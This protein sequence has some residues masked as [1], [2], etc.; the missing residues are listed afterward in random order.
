M[1]MTSSSSTPRSAT[2]EP[3]SP[4]RYVPLP[5]VMVRA[6][7]FPM[8]AYLS[9]AEGAP[10]APSGGTPR[11]EQLPGRGALSPDNRWVRLALAAGAPGLIEALGRSSDAAAHEKLLAF[12]IRMSTRPTPYGLFAGVALGAWGDRTNLSIADAAP[13]VGVRLDMEW[14]YRLIEQL[15]AR[16]QIRESL[17]VVA[18]P[19]ALVAGGRVFLTETVARV[20]DRRASRVSIRATRVVRAILRAARTPVSYTELAESMRASSGAPLE[21]VSRLLDDL[22]ERTFLLTDLRPPHSENPARHV[23]RRLSAIP[24]ARAEAAVLGALV[25][26]AAAWDPASD[27]PTDATLRDLAGR[28]RAI[29]QADHALQVDAALP[30]AGRTIARA[31]GDEFAR[32]AEILIRLTPFPQGITDFDAYRRRF[33]ARYGIGREVPVLEL[34]DPDFGLGPPEPTQPTVLAAR[35]A[36]LLRIATRALHERQTVVDLDEAILAELATW[37]PTK[38]GCPPSLDL[39]AF[40]SAPSAAALEADQFQ[41]IVGPAVGVSGAGRILGRFAGLL[42]QHGIDAARAAARAEENR[43]GLFAEVQFVPSRLRSANVVIRPSVRSYQILLGGVGAGDPEVTS[44]PLDDL[45][46]GVR[47]GRMY[48]RWPAGGADVI[49]CTGH[50]LSAALGPVIVPFL[51]DANRDGQAALSAF[52]WGPARTFP[53]LPRIQSGRVVLRLAEWRPGAILNERDREGSDRAIDILR[54]DWQLPRYVFSTEADNRLMLDLDD[55]RQRALLSRALTSRRSQGLVL[56]EALPAPDEVWAPGPG[57]RYVVELVASL[58]VREPK[59]SAPSDMTKTPPAGA[60][61]SIQARMRAPG[62]D[63]LF[64]KLYGPPCLQDD[65]LTAHMPSLVQDACERGLS[66]C[67][68]FIRY[69]DTDPHLRIRFHGTPERLSRELYPMLCRWAEDLI[70]RGICQRSVFDT[71]DREIER[72]GGEAALDEVERIFA[73]DSRAATRLLTASD[74]AAPARSA[75]GVLVADDL[76]DALGFDAAARLAWCRRCISSR[77]EASAEHRR[78]G[79]DLRMRLGAA[80]RD[81]DPVIAAL[82]ERRSAIDAPARALLRLHVEGALTAPLDGVLG[83]LVHM[84]LNRLLGPD[85]ALER[86]I[87]GLWL[88]T[89]ESLAA[90]PIPRCD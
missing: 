33:E 56:E 69:G 75:L 86:M 35:D 64:L 19:T 10:A 25:D 65:V 45:L 36:A 16:P 22:L 62:S 41:V 48:V 26:D 68:F 27:A 42:G 30:L 4:A 61:P 40:V 20:A 82:V 31:V 77:K 37:T 3:G 63:W 81:D 71:Y 79:A 55:P 58:A 51:C 80:R 46:A 13:A 67:W 85:R 44:I 15:E 29:V 6:P 60:P 23:A 24:A 28:A 34:L 12:S 57:G 9:L 39:F 78:I 89:R 8:E 18:N 21:K 73:A 43:P 11:P 50:V 88:R 70:T 38:E 2:P 54:R 87:L 90:H 84:S 7:L 53:R 59:A 5:F 49:G 32:A 1:I 74:R 52:H 17:S 76:L 72:Y 83:S 47:D 66:D 14:L